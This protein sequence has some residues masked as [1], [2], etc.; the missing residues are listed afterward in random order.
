MTPSG[1]YV[2]HEVI[3]S[4]LLDEPTQNRVRIIECLDRHPPW[5]DGTCPP[6]GTVRLS[7]QELHKRV[8]QFFGKSS[9][10][11]QLYVEADIAGD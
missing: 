1:D 4:A 10:A 7:D 9:L 5:S 3:K 8:R 11:K 2:C 6:P